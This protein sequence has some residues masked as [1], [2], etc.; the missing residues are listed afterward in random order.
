MRAKTLGKIIEV[1]PTWASA[2]G[3]GYQ[4]GY[5]SQAQKKQ[6]GLPPSNSYAIRV[7][8]VKTELV[9]ETNGY[10]GYRAHAIAV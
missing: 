7:D 4:M 6:L 2:T 8:G 10:T 3:V 1:N 9:K 5:L